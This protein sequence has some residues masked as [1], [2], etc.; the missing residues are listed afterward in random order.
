MTP[1]GWGGPSG[2]PSPSRRWLSRNLVVLTL[3]SLMQDAASE[4]VYPLLPLLITGVLAAPPVVLGVI[5]GVAE[6]TAGIARYVAGRWS[7]RAGRK[8]FIGAGYGLA[9][10]GKVLVAAAGSWPLVLAGR[11]VDRLG[12]GV[13]SAPRDALIAGSVPP[14]ALGRAFGFHRAGDTLG[15]VVGPLLGLWALTALQ[16]DLHAALWWA[17]VPAVVSAVLVF[18]VREPRPPESRVASAPPAP[19]MVVPVVRSPLPARFWRVAGVL[20]VIAL[21]NFSDTLVLLRVAELG[22]STVEVVGAYVLFNTVY[23]V[24]SY[25]AGVLTDRWPRPRVYAVGL[26]AFSCGYLGLGLTAGGP[27]VYVL[28]A[29]YGLFP[30]FTDGVG[31]AWVSSLVPDELRGRAQGVFQALSSG[32]IL[33]AGLWAG[34]LWG[35]GP[36][37]GVVPLIVAGGGGLLAA[38]ALLAGTSVGGRRRSPERGM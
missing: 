1:T 27:A 23:A 12:K 24:A 9:A 20:G 37:D 28:V 35:A 2:S 3:V 15:A 25:P 11:V 32:A 16:G 7:D 22:F 36:G 18:L 8:G 30:A 31:K 38:V 19:R 4:M 34:L 14:D 33:A 5:E 29:V 6:A 13:R 10:V 26:L 21:V 17:V